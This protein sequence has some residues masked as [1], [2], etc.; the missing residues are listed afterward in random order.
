M[1]GLEYNDPEDEPRGLPWARRRVSP[2]DRLRNLAVSILSGDQPPSE[3]AVQLLALLLQQS[4]QTAAALHRQIRNEL[5][6]GTDEEAEE[7][8]RDGP[9]ESLPAGDL[10]RAIQ[11]LLPDWEEFAKLLRSGGDEMRR[12]DFS[13]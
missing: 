7:E 4:P 2:E 9:D 5:A 10:Q 3:T 6:C 1:S 12:P 13:T 8:T 11:D